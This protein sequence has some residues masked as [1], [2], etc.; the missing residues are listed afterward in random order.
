M[1]IILKL[2]SPIIGAIVTALIVTPLVTAYGETKRRRMNQPARIL[3]LRSITR[4]VQT[5]EGQIVQS[6]QTLTGALATLDI[7]INGLKS[8]RN[9]VLEPG[10]D[11]TA[12]AG[13]SEARKVFVESRYFREDALK[14][15]LHLAGAFLSSALADSERAQKAISLYLP[16]LTPRERDRVLTIAEMLSTIDVSCRQMKDAL[17]ACAAGGHI[18]TKAG[19]DV[20]DFAPIRSEVRKLVQEFA[21]PAGKDHWLVRVNDWIMQNILR[22]HESPLRHIDL[23]EAEMK[24]ILG[25]MARFESRM[26]AVPESTHEGKQRLAI[27]L[28]EKRWMWELEQLELP[29]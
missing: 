6:F 16:L 24:E 18:A 3:F 17:T 20:A 2:L 29:S 1:D 15:D 12:A 28:C 13:L 19:L 21:M 4:A 23:S 22:V 11:Q 8:A 7:A 14:R 25:R 10:L 26:A 5:V 9:S 27:A